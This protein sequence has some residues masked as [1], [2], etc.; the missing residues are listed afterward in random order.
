M[1]LHVGISLIPFVHIKCELVI[2]REEIDLLLLGCEV[3]FGIHTCISGK[4]IFRQ[5]YHP[6]STG[7][8]YEKPEYSSVFTAGRVT[9]L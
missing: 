2:L 3:P 1:D 9:P 8:L 4:D 6:P 5:D 7:G